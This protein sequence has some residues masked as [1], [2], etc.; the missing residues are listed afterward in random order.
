MTYAKVEN[1][2]VVE[3]PL[4]PGDIMLRFPDTSFPIPFEAPQGYELVIQIPQ[5]SISYNQNLTEGDP[6]WIDGV[7]TQDWNIESASNQEITERTQ[8]KATEVR[9]QRNGLLAQSD[10]TQ[11]SDS[12][13]DKPAWADY[14]QELRDVPN[15]Q[16]FPWQVVWPEKP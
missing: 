1:G 16:G 7:L 8:Q 14:R 3:Y 12:T 15:Q 9:A 4:Y 13:A 11:L 5:P 2:A 6:V 10:W